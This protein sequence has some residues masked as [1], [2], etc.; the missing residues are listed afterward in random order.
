MLHGEEAVIPKANFASALAMLSKDM[1][2]TGMPVSE[3]AR[4]TMA[5]TTQ[6]NL[7][8]GI[9]RMVATNEKL[10]DHLNMLVMIGAKTEQNTKKTNINLAK[11]DGSLV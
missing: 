10:A 11:M 4:E 6:P 2:A 7:I 3:A 8:E 5:T 9:N 1:T